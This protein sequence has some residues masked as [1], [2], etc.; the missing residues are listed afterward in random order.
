MAC[1]N[2][3]VRQYAVDVARPFRLV[4]SVFVR[5]ADQRRNFNR[6][7]GDLEIQNAEL[8]RGNDDHLDVARLLV[9]DD[10]AR[11]ASFGRQRGRGVAGVS[12]R[13]AVANFRSF[14][15]VFPLPFEKEQKCRNYG[16]KQRGV[17]MNDDGE[18]VRYRYIEMKVTTDERI[19]DGYYYASAFK[20][21]KRI[22]ENPSVLEYP[23]EQVVE[24]ID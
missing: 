9:F 16:A 4:A 6:V 23:P 13:R 19:C 10:D 21:M 22:F 7:F 20:M 17:K 8:Y 5:V 24:D 12:S 1:R 2:R 3:F 18:V 15:G 11:R 14:M